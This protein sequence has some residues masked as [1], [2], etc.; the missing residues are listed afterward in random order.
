MEMRSLGRTNLKVSRL[1]LGLARVG[2][3]LTMD[4]LNE[5]SG[6]FDAALDA[7]VNFL[8]TAAC[9][10]ISETLV[11]RLLSQRRHQYV[12]AT[13]CGHVVEN[14]HGEPWT[15][16]TIQ[17]SIRR[18]LERMNTDYLDLIQLHSCD[19]DVLEEGSVI[20][21]LE[22]AKR[23]GLVRFIGYSGDND[24]ASWAVA[25][26]CFDTLQT[27]F[28]IVDQ[29]AR[30]S[31]LEAANRQGMGI[32]IK[33][34]I[35]NGTWGADKS[36]STYADDYFARAQVMQ[37]ADPVESLNMDRVSL[38]MAFVFS[39]AEV[40][41][42][43]IGTRNPKHMRENLTRFQ[44][45]VTIDEHLRDEIETRFNALGTHWPQLG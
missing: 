22:E 45:G 35:A 26:G 16:Q 33:R 38:A 1:G 34:P 5:A 3:E 37:A 20:N 36:P 28:N 17:H 32:I 8:D 4:D 23:D 43:I 42:A 2:Y 7:G 12:L 25:S 19:T 6:V 11:G 18:S 21:A 10:G 44:N 27:S 15:A 9:Y 40:D 41:T 13:K 14:D 29:K 39:Y 24:A 30:F 31:L